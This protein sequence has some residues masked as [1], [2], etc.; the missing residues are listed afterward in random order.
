MS[1]FWT[2]PTRIYRLHRVCWFAYRACWK[3]GRTRLMPPID[4]TRAI[5]LEGVAYEKPTV[6]PD[7][8]LN[9]GGDK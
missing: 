3:G 6:P 1:R 7:D 2:S 9:N 8:K 4:I 5:G